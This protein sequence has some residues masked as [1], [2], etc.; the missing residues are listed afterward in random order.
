MKVTGKVSVCITFSVICGLFAVSFGSVFLFRKSAKDHLEQL[1]Y[2]KVLEMEKGL[3]PERKLAIQLAQSPAV[4]DYMANPFDEEIR[5]IAFRDF[6]TFQDSFSSHRTFWISD[7][8]LKYYSNMEYIYDLDKSDPANAWYQA[9]INTNLPF[10]FYVD[11]DVGLKKTFMWINVLVYNENRKVTGITGTG[12]E[13][14]DFVTSM[15]ATLEDGVTMYMYNANAEIS[16]SLA[17]SDLER[18]VPIT[19][20]MPE[21]ADVRNLFPSDRIFHETFKGVYLIAPIDS[22]RWELVLFIPF[23]VK[24]FFL[25]AMVPFACLVILSVLIL[26]AYTM[27]NLFKPLSEIHGTV[28]NI[29]SGEADLTRRLSTDLHTPFKSIHNIVNYFNTFM[30]KLQGMIGTIKSS[31]KSLDVVSQ[32][33]KESVASVSNSMTSIRTGIEDIYNQIHNQSQGFIGATDAV[34]DVASSITTVNKMIDSQT[35]SIR[36]SSASVGQLV[37]SIEDISGSMESMASSFNLLDS[38]AQSGMSKQEKVNERISQIEEQSHMLQE[39]NTAIAAIAEQTNLLAM[40]AAIEAAH[41]G[42]AGKGFAVV[43]D[44]IR[45]LSETSSGQSKTIG[46]QLNK[47]Q[48]SIGDIVT[49]SLESSS[50]FSGV[51]S[52]IQETDKLVR[53]IQEALASQNSDSRSVI[54]SLAS[55]DKTAENVREASEKM[56]EGSSL[57]LEEMDNLQTSLKA[58]QDG[59]A[60]ISEN[61]QSVV[62]SGMRL[63]SCVEELDMNVTQLGSDVRRFKTE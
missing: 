47:I 3:L 29:A 16:A 11:Y 41:A 15:Y 48:E 33:M 28:R 42:D 22:L 58:V 31:S 59:M 45:K 52:R 38:E 10:Q 63:D 55:M 36:D 8:D 24:A 34:R 44:E 43:A 60:A 1:K 14:T 57:V 18:K 20:A 54:E 62:K 40:N 51:S 4:V 21:L 32:N 7:S 30:E 53:S 17:L 56:A 61:A 23:T 35:K 9:T 19:K 2:T 6:K 5:A 25:N 12:V 39:A 27:H 37:K 49:A 13:L 26:I 50:A 46:D